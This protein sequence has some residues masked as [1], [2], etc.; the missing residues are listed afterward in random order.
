M[1]I[2]R[3]NLTDEIVGPYQTRRHAIMYRPARDRD[4]WVPVSIGRRTKEQAKALGAELTSA[5]VAK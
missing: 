4:C 5:R 2:L 3:H 1:F